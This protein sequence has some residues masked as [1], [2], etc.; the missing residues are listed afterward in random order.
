[1]KLKFQM[2]IQTMLF[3]KYCSLFENQGTYLIFNLI[4]VAQ[5]TSDISFNPSIYAGRFEQLNSEK[6]TIVAFLKGIDV[7]MFNNFNDFYIGLNDVV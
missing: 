6:Q 3:N 7:D 4:L 2:H 5:K 1:M